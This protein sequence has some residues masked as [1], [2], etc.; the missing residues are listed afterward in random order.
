M[1]RLCMAMATLVSAFACQGALSV[2]FNSA[3]E[4][5]RG[6]Q[7]RSFANGAVWSDPEKRIYKMRPVLPEGGRT[8]GIEGNGSTVM[9]YFP[10]YGE[11][12]WVRVSLAGD[13]QVT[14]IGYKASNIY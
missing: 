1:K 5:E 12:N 13:E 11:G 2:K 9:H 10:Q 3:M 8:F 14:L 4:V 7:V 6:G